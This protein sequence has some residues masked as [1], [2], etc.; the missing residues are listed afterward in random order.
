MPALVS[1][2]LPVANRRILVVSGSSSCSGDSSSGGS[3]LL[4]SLALA[5]TP[6]PLPLFT[7]LLTP[8]LADAGSLPPRF[9]QLAQERDA[10]WCGEGAVSDADTDM[11]WLGGALVLTCRCPRSAWPPSC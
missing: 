2:P 10:V 8:Q 6:P 1:S 7:V 5:L 4:G 9:F 11:C 3:S